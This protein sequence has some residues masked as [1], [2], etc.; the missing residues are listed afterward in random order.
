MCEFEILKAE[1]LSPVAAQ[2]N[3]SAATEDM[4]SVATEAVSSVATEDLSSFANG[5]M[6]SVA[7]EFMY[8][9][10]TEDMSSVATEDMSS[11]AAEGMSDAATEDMSSVATGDISPV[12]TGACLFRCNRSHALDLRDLL[13]SSPKCVL[14][15]QEPLRDCFGGVLGG[16]LGRSPYIYKLPVNRPWRPLYIYIYRTRESK[17][18]DGRERESTDA[19]LSTWRARPT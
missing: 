3:S 11:V 5:D 10:A 9:V 1:D 6:S 16:T 19:P 4:S 8:S 12:A 18:R 14:V 2:Y 17:K 7:T 13:A 15:P